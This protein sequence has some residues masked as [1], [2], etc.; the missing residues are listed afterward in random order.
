MARK[1]GGLAGVYDRNKKYV[2]AIAPVLLGAIPGV[3]MPLAVA[4][5]AAMGADREG[6]SYFKNFDVGG[7][8]KGGVAGYGQGAAGA[9]IKGLLTGG[10]KS[11]MAAGEGYRQAMNSYNKPVSKLFGGG[12]KA[13]AA[14]ENIPRTPPGLPDAANPAGTVTPAPSKMSW[15]SAMKQPQVLASAIQTGVGM[16]PSAETR[17]AEA[18]AQTAMERTDMERQ[19]LKMEQEELE[20]QRERR[21]RMAQLLMPYL[22]QQYPQYFSQMQQG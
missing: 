7:A 8:I 22:E 21:R 14:G 6:K 16:L 9:G 15:G 11:N 13:S 17:I 20:A 12:S 1:R 10:L 4:A 2:K 18:N 19:R 5:G 3:G